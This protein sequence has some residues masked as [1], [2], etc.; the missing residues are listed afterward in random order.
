M[1]S[2]LTNIQA[3]DTTSCTQEKN[4][5]ENT[6]FPTSIGTTGS[7]S[8]ACAHPINTTSP[9][10]ES[11]S[12]ATAYIQE[13][14]TTSPIPENH[15]P[16]RNTLYLNAKQRRC[17]TAAAETLRRS[18]ATLERYRQVLAG[19]AATEAHITQ[20]LVN[21]ALTTIT[22]FKAIAH[23]GERARTVFEKAQREHE[24]TLRLLV[25]DCER[26]VTYLIG[27]DRMDF[28]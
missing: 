19:H 25:R 16:R 28:E 21:A 23:P 8:T 27:E 14:N 12:T 10:P 17:A 11:T 26:R 5:N 22:T 3:S 20:P 18:R 2:T 15:H 9:T 13:S 4:E 7:T 6:S 24:Q 1:A